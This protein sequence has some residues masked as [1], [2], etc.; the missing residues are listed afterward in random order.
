MNMASLQ[1]LHGMLTELGFIHD[2]TFRVLTHSVSTLELEAHVQSDS[3]RAIKDAGHKKR[4]RLVGR[5]GRGSEREE[6]D[7][8]AVKATL[9]ALFRKGNMGTLLKALPDQP[10]TREPETRR[11]IYQYTLN[12][13]VPKHEPDCAHSDTVYAHLERSLGPQQPGVDPIESY[14]AACEF[15]DDIIKGVERRL[16]SQ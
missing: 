8:G 3:F 1:L 6:W 7:A 11:R 5:L 10:P 13:T 9:T 4:H 2:G 16:S 12:Y 14:T 15:L